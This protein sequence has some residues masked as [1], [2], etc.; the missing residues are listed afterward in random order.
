MTRSGE[1]GPTDLAGLLSDLPVVVWE[2]D[3]ST[4][5]LTFVS[6][7]AEELLGFPVDRWL[8]DWDSVVHPD[9]R[10]AVA[11]ERWAGGADFALAYRVVAADGRVLWVR[12]RGRA[13]PAADGSAGLVRGVLADVTESRLR[14]ERERFLGELDRELQRFDDAEEV[15]TAATRLLG[16]HMGVNRCAYAEAEADEDHFLMSGDYSSGLPPLPGRFAMSDFGAG[17]LRAMRGGVPWVVADSLDDPRL[18]PADLHAYR[19]TGIRAVICLPLL[20]GGRFVAAMAV[21]QAEVRHWTEADVELVTVVVNRCWESLQRTHADRALR[22]SEERHRLLVERAT[23]GI[24]TVDRDLRFADA[25]PA[26][27][28]L[29][30]YARADL[31]GRPLTDLVAADLADR[32]AELVG[33]P[34]R[35]VT[36]V[37]ELRRADGGAVPLELSIQSTPTGL[38]AIGRDVTE[39]RRAEAERERLLRRE[40]E[41]AEALQH[42]LLPRELPSLP[43]VAVAARY[44]PAATHGQIGGDWYEVLPVGGSVVALSVGDVVGK[45]PTAAAVMGQ[46]RSALAGYLLD[47]HSPAAALERL[48]AFAHRTPGALGSTCACLTFDWDTGLLCWS[49]AGHLPALLVTETGTRFLTDEAGAVLGAPERGPYRDHEVEVPV[50][51]SVV[52][53]TDGLVERREAV[54]DVGLE[55]LAAVAGALHGAG[56]D[57][58]ADEVVGALLAE[59]QDDDVALVVLRRVPDP[60]DRREVPA[61]PDALADMRREVRAWAALAGVSTDHLCDVQLALG[62]AAANA[63]DHAYPDGPGRF[64]YLLDR[65]AGGDVRVVVRDR[66]RWRP[67][68]ADKGH[69][70]RGIGIIRELGADVVFDRGPAGTTVDFRVPADPD[71]PAVELPVAPSSGEH[72][73]VRLTGDLDAAGAGAARADLLARVGGGPVELDLTDLDYLSSSGIALLLEAAGTARAAGHRMTWALRSGSA[74][75]RIVALSGLTGVAGLDVRIA[76]EEPAAR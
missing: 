65:T 73:V 22:A 47:H 26:A 67:E 62:E 38:Q 8:A 69:R 23:D 27:C 9:D 14:E 48:D 43:R 72:R 66:G 40:R 5:R 68:P 54:V 58:L 28:E 75:A 49:A 70:G 60:L 15:M 63:V 53:Y 50:G 57:E 1:P 24:W 35:V 42:S 33:E 31:L 61:V 37:W 56:P 64:D 76:T 6:R 19:V 52:L 12:E 55:R 30:G 71:R 4:R 41:I 46:L 32:L 45:G 2:G 51:A 11:R 10:D 59:G 13:V 34:G 44:L 74:P 18:T 20:R 39:R 3:A 21:H 36:D 17:A 16:E 25:N 29:L 7:H